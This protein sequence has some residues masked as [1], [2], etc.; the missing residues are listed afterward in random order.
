[1]SGSKFL[2]DTNIITAWI[3]G[4]KS[5]ADKVEKASDVCVGALWL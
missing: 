2:L 5:I 4:E 1:M 3:K